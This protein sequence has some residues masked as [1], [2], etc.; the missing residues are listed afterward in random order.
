MA[1]P[2]DSGPSTPIRDVG[3]PG[4][5]AILVAAQA[6]RTRPTCGPADGRQWSFE[7]P[8][9]PRTFS[10]EV[11]DVERVM[12]EVFED[13]DPDTLP[14]TF[15]VGDGIGPGRG[16]ATHCDGATC[17]SAA[18]GTIEVLVF[19]PPSEGLLRYEFELPSGEI[20]A[21]DA[22]IPIHCD[23]FGGCG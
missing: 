2:F 10:C 6:A 1:P 8:V 15:D 17:T 4:P 21:S 7:I 18:R 23:G 22:T 5:D 3:P 11:L 13:L 12:L 19:D 14:R 9:V 20:M 16:A